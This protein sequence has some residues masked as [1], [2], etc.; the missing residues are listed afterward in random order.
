MGVT[1]TGCRDD[2]VA[3]ARGHNRWVLGRTD[4]DAPSHSDVL[5]TAGAFLHRVLSNAS[6]PGQR[7]VFD[8]LPVPGSMET[9]YVIGAARP[10]TIQAL[11]PQTPSQALD[12]TAK[13]GGKVLARFSDCPTSRAL[14]A[15]KPWIVLAEFD[16]RAPSKRIAWPERAV[17][18]FGIP[19]DSPMSLDWLLLAAAHTGA[20]AEADTKWEDEVATGTKREIA[21][22]LKPYQLSG[23]MVA[24]SVAVGAVGLAV[25][26]FAGK[27]RRRAAA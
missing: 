8:V 3:I 15:D 18:P 25:W 23:A 5:Q 27:R 12:F 6:P 1:L 17:D 11:Q 2:T 26:H 7:G 19:T 16:W 22:A 20:A 14:Q 24:A 13:P 9:R 10:L 21:K 4:R